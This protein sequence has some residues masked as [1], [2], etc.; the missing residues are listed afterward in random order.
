[1]GTVTFTG[2]GGLTATETL[3]GGVATTTLTASL[4]GTVTASYAGNA[5]SA[6]SSEELDV[7]KTPTETAVTAVPNP[8]D[9][10]ESVMLTATVTTVPPGGTPAGSV[11]FTGPG[12]LAEAAVRD[13]GGVATVTTS[14]LASGTVTARFL[15]NPVFAASSGTVAVTVNLIPTETSVTASPDPSRPART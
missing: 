13:A 10:G 4:A 1:M 11:R 6:A 8:S 12:G 9:G 7:D 3:A 15:G 14:A 5:D 2:P